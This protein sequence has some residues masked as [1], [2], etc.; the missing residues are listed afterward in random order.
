MP[1]L[2][3]PCK[4][5]TKLFPE[6]FSE[7]LEDQERPEGAPLLHRGEHW[8]QGIQ[9]ISGFRTNILSPMTMVSQLNK[10]LLMKNK[11]TLK[12]GQQ[13]EVIIFWTRSKKI[14]FYP[15]IF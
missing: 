10:I 12:Q 6:I 3:R 15:D 14:I 13:R 8:V 4:V 1:S 5:E 11:M 9:I 2:S 7:T